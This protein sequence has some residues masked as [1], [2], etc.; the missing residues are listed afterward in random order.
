MKI[1]S[2]LLSLSIVLLFSACS[3][4]EEPLTVAPKTLPSWYTSPLQNNHNFLYEVAE[5]HDKKEAIANALDM[6]AASLST[7]V[8]SNYK[9]T[10]TTD[11]GVNESYQHNVE[12]K[13]ELTVEEIRISN[14]SVVESV[15]QSFRRYLVL[16][17]S[18]KSILFS[19]LKNELDERAHA[20][21]EQEENVQNKNVLEQLQFYN[22]AKEA[23]STL[24]QTLN[25]MHVL[26]TNF[27]AKPY[28]VQAQ[29]YT[30]NYNNLRANVTFSFQSN[31]DAKQL[32]SVLSSGLNKEGM[33]IQNRNDIYHLSIEVNA[34]VEEAQSMDFDLARTA[35]TISV[36]DQTGTTLGS[37]KLNITGQSTQGYNIARENVAIKLKRLVEAEGIQSILGIQ[38]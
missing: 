5:G 12:Q 3:S 33:H 9:S 32:L 17:K 15:Q 23:Y 16:I 8:S 22:Q 36:Q 7:T 27:D 1:T 21:K 34:N 13:V 31:Q 37:N 24:Q 25:V 4:K 2:L 30:N 26:N 20:L 35:I 19:S 28:V 11:S 10:T 6:M 18:D 29:H 14:F 38:F